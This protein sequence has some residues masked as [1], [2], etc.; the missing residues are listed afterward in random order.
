MLGK[1]L[2]F[3]PLSALLPVHR[4][5]TT[6]QVLRTPLFCRI[7]S[8]LSLSGCFLAMAWLT[9]RGDTPF[10]LLS[11]FLLLPGAFRSIVDRKERSR[12]PS[13]V[14]NLNN[15]HC[16]GAE[17]GGAQFFLSPGESNN[18]HNSPDSPFFCTRSA[19]G[20]FLFG[21]PACFPL[22]F[23]LPGVKQAMDR[24]NAIG[25]L[26]SFGTIKIN[27]FFF[28]TEFVTTGGA[29]FFLSFSSS[30]PVQDGA[31]GLAVFLL[32]LRHWQSLLPSSAK[33]ARIIHSLPSSPP[34]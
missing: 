4:A 2:L 13:S 27:V 32:S 23:S 11:P 7:I 26:S 3:F 5:C 14:R 25:A 24:T 10:S 20:L 28:F 29:F 17:L 18:T 15:K 9:L 33:L 21:S 1:I 8:F 12:P 22:P 34:P 31:R 19:R 16:L 30:P 6:L